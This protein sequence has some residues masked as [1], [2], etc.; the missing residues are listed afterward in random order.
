MYI[1]DTLIRQLLVCAFLSACNFSSAQGSEDGLEDTDIMDASMSMVSDLPSEDISE[2]PL[3]GGINLEPT[4]LSSD[5]DQLVQD[6]VGDTAEVFVVNTNSTENIV[7]I[8]PPQE[9]DYT[10][11]VDAYAVNN[12]WRN[13]CPCGFH[14]IR[15]ARKIPCGRDRAVDCLPEECCV[16]TSTRTC[17]EWFDNLGSCGDGEPEKNLLSITVETNCFVDHL[18][19]CVAREEFEM[20]SDTDKVTPVSNAPVVETFV[21]VTSTAVA[22]ATKTVATATETETETEISKVLKIETESVVETETRTE[23]L[24]T[25]TETKTKTVVTE[26]TSVVETETQTQV[27]TETKLHSIITETATETVTEML[28]D[29]ADESGTDDVSMA[30]ISN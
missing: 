22:T 3:A 6:V 24:V 23:G 8:L 28:S 1:K 10:T 27:E 2:M 20:P 11:C 7:V 19:C 25:E 16:E 12:G 17:A 9:A 21:F 5:L 13:F 14:P 15:S 30:E 4:E 18:A 26:T 29:L